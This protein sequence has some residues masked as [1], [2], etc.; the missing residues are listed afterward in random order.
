MEIGGEWQEFKH[1]G[2]DVRFETT[3]PA[4]SLAMQ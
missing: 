3:F 4:S 1:G 2:F